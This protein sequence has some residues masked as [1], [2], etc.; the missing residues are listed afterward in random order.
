M[1]LDIES[2]DGKVELFIGPYSSFYRFR[3]Q[4]AKLMGLQ[5]YCKDWKEPLTIEDFMI[6]NFGASNGKSLKQLLIEDELF[7]TEKRYPGTQSFFNHSDCEGEWTLNECKRILDIINDICDRLLDVKEVD[8]QSYEYWKDTFD[9]FKSGL[10][11][12]V[13]NEQKAIFT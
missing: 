10:K 8:E 7:E 2:E 5:Q 9:K 3:Q 1:G 11:Y 4:V 12:C 13:K 6:A